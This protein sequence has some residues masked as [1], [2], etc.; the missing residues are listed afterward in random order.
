M[1][2]QRK[3]RSVRLQ[4]IE[5][6][7]Q[8]F[9]QRGFHQTSFSDIA[10]TAAISRG[11]FYYHFKSK[12]EILAAV[13]AYRLDAIRRMLA[14]WDTSISDPKARLL[15]Y[16]D[17][18]RNEEEDILRYGCPMGSLNMEL[19]KSQLA[20][21]SQVV[22]MFNVFQAW[23]ETQFRQLVPAAD[24]TGHSLH[25]LTVAQ[26]IALMATVQKDPAWLHGEVEKL[27]QWINSLIKR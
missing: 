7:N 18:L 4:I 12:D 21:Q 8:L 11:N 20:L 17:I 27:E 19:A 10:R 22:A 3:S 24:V 1:S 16:V 5:A 13:V 14:E 23:L 25:L 15:R 6:A 26:G 2:A 9:Y